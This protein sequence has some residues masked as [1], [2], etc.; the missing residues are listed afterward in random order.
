MQM[1]D[2]VVAINGSDVQSVDDLHR[3]LSEWPIGQP[4]EI[5]IVRG[6]TR[7]VLTIIP[8]EAIV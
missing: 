6:Q 1:R 5:D 7:Q 3:F 2:L 8:K 4:V